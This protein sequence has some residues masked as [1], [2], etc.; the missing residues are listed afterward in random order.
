MREEAVNFL[1]AQS[2]PALSLGWKLYLAAFVGHLTSGPNPWM[3][4]FPGTRE[5]KL[6][7]LFVM[8]LKDVKMCFPFVKKASM[9]K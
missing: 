3:E 7:F 2:A 4:F 1:L 9:R 5:T 6:W 8:T